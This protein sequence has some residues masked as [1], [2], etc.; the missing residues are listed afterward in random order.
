M[1]E[2]AGGSIASNSRDCDARHCGSDGVPVQPRSGRVDEPRMQDRAPDERSPGLPHNGTAGSAGA[3]RGASASPIRGLA[4][5][6]NSILDGS[7]RTLRA[8]RR[9]VSAPAVAEQLDTVER[10]L[11][12][13][14]NTLERTLRSPD[15]LGTFAAFPVTAFVARQALG[16]TVRAVVRAL[17]DYAEESSVAIRIECDPDAARLDAGPLEPVLRNAIRNAIEACSGAPQEASTPLVTVSLRLHGQRLLIDVVDNGPGVAVATLSRARPIVHG[18]GLD[19]AR[20]V[21]T[22]LGGELELSNI[23]FGRG[24]VLRAEIP[25]GRLRRPHAA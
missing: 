2:G 23:P 12:S 6:L 15:A 24:A 19:V 7:L 13:M 22:S 16:D 11:V 20:A 1:P 21:L 14:A 4:H 10:A 25:V 5:E 8:A 17:A 3:P 18:I 9:G